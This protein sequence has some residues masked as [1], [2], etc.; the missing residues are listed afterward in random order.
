M[1]CNAI[2]FAPTAK[3]NWLQKTTVYIE[4]VILHIFQ[5]KSVRVHV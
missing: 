4:N 3:K 1:V 2:A 5:K